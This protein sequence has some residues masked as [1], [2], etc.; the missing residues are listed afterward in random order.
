MSPQKEGTTRYERTAEILF[1]QS[2]T[3]GSTHI[4]MWSP[5]AT[6][7]T[8]IPKRVFENTHGADLLTFRASTDLLEI[9]E[10]VKTLKMWS[11]NQTVLHLSYDRFPLRGIEQLT[12]TDPAGTT[13]VLPYA[14]DCQNATP[15]IGQESKS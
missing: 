12:I 9:N 15:T 4:A 5:S 14:H 13:V 11:E 8:R 7:T 6:S 3:L 2:L 1:V 10:H